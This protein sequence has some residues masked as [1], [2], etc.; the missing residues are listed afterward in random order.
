[1]CATKVLPAVESPLL[2]RLI[3]AAVSL[4]CASTL[5][6]AATCP[7]SQ[8]AFHGSTVF[9]S[10]AAVFD[11]AEA[12][13]PDF[14]VSYDLPQGKVSMSQPGFLSATFVEAADAYDLVGVAAG[15]AV[16]L[17]AQFMVDG[18]V[19][20]PGCGGTGCGGYV[21]IR[22][23]HG[24]LFD[25]MRHS[26]HLFQGSQSFHDMR[27]IP[28]TIV[29][30]APEVLQ[31]KLEGARTP[32]GAHASEATGTIL[33]AGLPLG[34]AVTSCQGYSIRATPVRRAS[35]GSIKSIYR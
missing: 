17:T 29:A 30:G 2:P 6:S 9:S 14:H 16:N 7:S 4:A 27:S 13:F 22:I 33:F 32:G 12:G 19:S 3:V 10:T 26:I 21:T 31:F 28:V 24:A 20:T 34:A 1:M 23:S 15:T 35:W 18:S 11:S 25:E 8:M 5:A